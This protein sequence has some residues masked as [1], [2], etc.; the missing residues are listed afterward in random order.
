MPA[1]F[2]I[3]CGLLSAVVAFAPCAR[4]AQQDHEHPAEAGAHEGEKAE[5]AQAGHDADGGAHDHIGT[6]N[7]SKGLTKP[8]E[9]KTDLSIATFL[10]F[11][12]LLAILWK[13]A[14]GPIVAA[15]ERR[16]AAV[17][18]HIAQAERAHERAKELLAEYEQKLAG[19]ANQ[20]RELLEE[21]RRD[22]E[23]TKL[24]ILVEAKKGAELE[25]A[26]ALRDIEAAADTAVESLAR[27]SSDLAI[28]L[29]GKIIQ[30][31]L[32]KADHAR[33]IQEAVAKFPASTN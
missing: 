8:Q 30:A 26:R 27:R 14:W 21:A 1:R 5:G 33:L 6:A 15:L 22:A 3:A 25:K 31:Q 4:A 9:F 19:A 16:E 10:V 28:E 7:A 23:H 32:S 18:E 20:V 29:A 13:F 11:L 17:A 12:V 24:D 2:F